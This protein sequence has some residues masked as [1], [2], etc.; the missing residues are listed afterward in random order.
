VCFKASSKIVPQIRTEGGIFSC[1]SPL[2]TFVDSLLNTTTSV[3]VYVATTSYGLFWH[4]DIVY[5]NEHWNFSSL[6]NFICVKNSVPAF[7]NLYK[8]YFL[9]FVALN[10]TFMFLFI[11]LVC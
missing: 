1:T 5:T 8:Q 9:N 2:E 3:L 7:V 10:V 11:F 6:L 4:F